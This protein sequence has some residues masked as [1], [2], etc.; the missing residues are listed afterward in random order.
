MGGT[1]DFIVIGAQR[2][3]TTSLW[4]HLSAHP[5]V[6]IPA[7]KEAPFFGH[8]TFA[9]GLA[10]YLR[11]YFA[12]ADPGRVWGTVTPQYMLGSPEADEAELAERIHT[13]VPAVRLVAVLR[14]PVERA[15]S[16]HR[17][18]VHR[19][20]ETRSFDE[21]AA[22][23][24]EPAA[25]EDARRPGAAERGLQRYL[26][27]GEYG[28]ILE[29]FRSRFG[30]EQLHVVLTE[31]LEHD[32]AATVSGVLGF[33]GLDPQVQLPDLDV[34]H[35]RGGRRRRIDADAETALKAYLARE[36]WP[37]IAHPAL[38]ERAFDFWFMQWNV[39]PDEAFDPVDAA[40]LERLRS[41]FASDGARLEAV[42]GRPVPW[43]TGTAAPAAP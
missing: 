14:D 28:R 31:E 4:R 25:L 18:N 9:L 22:A 26:V 39:V 8:H 2:S 23:L 15:R 5:D 35:N 17:L 20:V 30:A 43:A 24:L 42:I 6:H 29:P 12:D 33:L 32:P 27:A 40:L 11:E 7:S 1:L 41:H 36:V 34:R 16:Q 19:G 3:G 38:A 21:A 13:T 37:A 10:W